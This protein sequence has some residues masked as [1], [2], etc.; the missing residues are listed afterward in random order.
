LREA[1][2]GAAI[3]D[4][5]Q[6]EAGID[7]QI[8]DGQR[9]AFIILSNHSED[10]L[11]KNRDYLY[12][13]V[14]GG[15]TEITI[16]AQGKVVGSNSFRIGTVRILHGLDAELE[17]IEMRKWVKE[18]TRSYKG[19]IA[20][21]SGGNINKIFRLAR[22]KEGK[23]ISCDQIKQIKAHIERF[24]LN[25]RIKILR[26]RPDRADVIIPAIDVYLAVSKWAKIE[27]MYVPQIGLA[28]GMIHMLYEQFKEEQ[29]AKNTNLHKPP[30]G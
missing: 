13:D 7:L 10:T 24:S 2:N 16:V 18:K 4:R 12:I 30:A 11:D 25:D 20:I 17:W 21:G 26:L 3:A 14:G 19:L 9:E 23:P 22:K 28:D 5:V 29:T 27:K 8:I 15:S 1:I 6:Q